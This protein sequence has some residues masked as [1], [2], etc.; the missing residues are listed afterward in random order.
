[1]SDCT[2]P[3]TLI[4][5]PP[6]TAS[7]TGAI[8][9]R[10]V[11]GSDFMI[12]VIKSLGI[13]HVF[14]NPGSSFLGLHESI[15]NYGGN[16][17]PEFIT[18]L[19]EES[20]VA[21]ANGRYKAAGKPAAA[22]RHSTVGLQHA[23]MALYNGWYDR[24]PVVTILGNTLDL[25][26][27]MGGNDWRHS[28][29]DPVAMVRDFI[30]WDDRPTTLQGF[31]ESFVHGCKIVCT[32]PMEPVAIVA[33]SELQEV[34]VPDRA[35]LQ[36]PKLSTPLPPQGDANAVREAARW[37][38]AAKR[39][40]IIVDRL[41]RT[42]AGMARL[43]ELAEALSAQADVILGLEV[44]DFWGQMNQVDRNDK[45]SRS[46]LTPGT[47]TITI[48]VN[49]LYMKSNYQD[50][51][52]H[53]PVDLAISGDG[54]ATLPALIEAVRAQIG[55][56][57][58]ASLAPRLERFRTLH[59]AAREAARRAAAFDRDASPVRA[60]VSA[61]VGRPRSARHLQTGRSGAFRSTSSGTATSCMRTV[62]CRHAA[63]A[64][65]A[66]RRGQRGL[67]AHDPAGEMTRPDSGVARLAGSRRR[68]QRGCSG[69]SRSTGPRFGIRSNRSPRASRLP[70]G[71]RQKV[72]F[73]F[74]A[75]TSRNAME[76]EPSET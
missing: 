70:S 3:P 40:V 71:I 19:H 39:P 11:C 41:A 5:A 30:Q 43:V 72:M 25:T 52:R 49:D 20:A 15:V 45:S 33:D 74:A 9:A 69:A 68:P 60:A 63:R 12:D 55:A 34:E 47:K 14:S 73:L 27:R 2:R 29:Q 44:T 42:P 23:A 21:M 67:P 65:P 6:A 59:A 7:A 61:M 24:V 16:K 57:R 54:A 28:A 53:A 22:L 64:G 18:C 38:V 1:M 35:A 32:P 66:A 51:Q 31:A 58:R 48:D 75:C 76:S 62:R 26:K 36:V 4:G 50:F 37:L 17:A 46:K 56:E 8:A 13:D 10:T